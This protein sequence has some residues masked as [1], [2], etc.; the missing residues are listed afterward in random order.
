MPLLNLDNYVESVFQSKI[1]EADDGI[2]TSPM[3][4]TRKLDA[5]I[6]AWSSHTLYKEQTVFFHLRPH[7]PHIWEGKL[8]L[9]A[10][11]VFFRIRFSENFLC[12]IFGLFFWNI[13]ECRLFFRPG[14][15][16]NTSSRKRGWFLDS[17]FGARSRSESLQA[18]SSPCRLHFEK[19]GISVAFTLC[20]S[21][22]G[23][24][25]RVMCAIM[26]AFSRNTTLKRG[27]NQ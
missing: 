18:S 8:N 6:S 5:L 10:F 16:K 23:L 15:P 19:N 17:P 11:M 24:D 26:S 20:G 1:F 2:R 21:E 22:K 12:S 7:F 27:K 9:L 3:Q 14:E 4:K 13:P 25:L